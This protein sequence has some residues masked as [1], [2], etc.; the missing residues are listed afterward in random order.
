MSINFK[1]CN[2]YNGYS[3]Y[4]ANPPQRK[5]DNTVSQPQAPSRQP[6]Q[7][8]GADI[9]I[10]SLGLTIGGEKVASK[11][12]NLWGKLNGSKKREEEA[13][14]AEEERIRQEK[15]AEY[16]R[17]QAEY[18]QKQ[19]EEFAKR[20]AEI[21]A[22]NAEHC[23]IL[24][25]KKAEE[26]RI[27]E[28]ERIKT[29]TA[30][31]NY[32]LKNGLNDEVF[33]VLNP[34]EKIKNDIHTEV[35]EKYKEYFKTQGLYL[36]GKIPH[37]FSWEHEQEL[38][39]EAVNNFDFRAYNEQLDKTKPAEI[40]SIIGN[41]YEND[42]NEGKP[43]TLDYAIGLINQTVGGIYTMDEAAKKSKYG[44]RTGYYPRIEFVAND[45][46]KYAG[47]L[48]EEINYLREIEGETASIINK[49]V[50]HV[51]NGTTNVENVKNAR[52]NEAINEYH[53]ALEP[54]KARLEYDEN[55][56]PKPEI[57]EF[58][59]EEKAELA[60]ELTETLGEGWHQKVDENS[61]IGWMAE[62]WKNKYISTPF[63]MKNKKAENAFL[64][65][66]PRY[67]GTRK[68]SSGRVYTYKS[69]D[70]FKYSPLYRQM[71]VENPEEFIKEFESNIGGEYAPGRLQSC[72]KEKY[73]GECWG[74][75]FNTRY[76]F[77]DWNP[78]YNIKM[79]IHP[80]GPTSNAADIGE[81]KYGDLEAIYAAD[82]KFKVLG[83]VKRRI[84]PE[85]MEKE[86]PD[87][88][89]KFDDF[90]RYEVHLQEM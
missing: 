74:G 82:S 52:Y 58:T 34:L 2:S 9:V 48:I 42:V 47:K 66:M 7:A 41:H 65:T 54:I 90:E 57:P 18:K 8:S 25:A 81:G 87:F 76:G 16:I 11:M 40:F 35:D 28:E 50:E 85:E 23:R 19:A 72:S 53:T 46:R 22:K 10:Q 89:N 69:N 29:E 73:Y 86:I 14:K 27:A 21:E 31:A 88:T 1:S 59:Q 13:K 24:E 5:S 83:T 38:Q 64:A 79:V 20:R 67:D 26:A 78:N 12:K 3:N 39:K 44:E 36:R 84:T 45:Y 75:M 49:A 17:K 60:K 15:Q 61:T 56:V 71:N 4:S 55:Y 30:S 32:S 80:K 43:V 51:N 62:A 68:Y 37:E 33:N 70:G 6:E 77:A 63:S